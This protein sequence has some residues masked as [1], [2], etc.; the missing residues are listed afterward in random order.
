MGFSHSKVETH[1]SCPYKYKLRYVDKLKPKPDLSPTNALYIGTATHE[2]IENR[3]IDKALDSY[4][5]NYP[6]ISKDNE[7]EM[8][9]IRKMLEIAIAEIPEGIYEFKINDVDGFI[10]FIDM[11]V[12]VEPGIYDLYD[13]KTSNSASKYKQSTQVHVY[14]YYYEKLTGNKIRNLYYAMVPKSTVKLADCESYDDA[15]AKVDD[16][17]KDKSI[18]F[19]KVDFDRS[20]VGYFFARKSAMDTSDKT[21]SYTKIYSTLCRFC[22]YNKYCST[23]GKDRS[24]LIDSDNEYKEVELF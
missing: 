7:L 16:F 20:K 4:R 24:E 6:D 15:I 5:S 12:E 8:Y 19:V 9:K 11:L 10:G 2:G 14:K 22:E 1:H 23:N 17:F 21:G 13:F 18:N 3:N